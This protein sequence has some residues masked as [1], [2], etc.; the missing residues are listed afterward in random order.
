MLSVHVAVPSECLMF[1]DI[2]KWALHLLWILVW[3]SCIWVLNYYY[4]RLMAVCPGLSRWAGNRKVKPIWILPKQ[5]TVSGSGISWAICKY[6]PH[7]RQKTTTAPHH[8][9][10]SISTEYMFHSSREKTA[11]VWQTQQTDRHSSNF[12]EIFSLAGN[13]CRLW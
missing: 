9:T 3:L 12:S 10:T 4:T 1:L 8:N 5:E 7:S 2:L 11:S 13:E 6:A